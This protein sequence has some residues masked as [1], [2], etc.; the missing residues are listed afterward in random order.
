MA[1]A[2]ARGRY[3]GARSM[4]VGAGFLIAPKLGTWVWQREGPDTL[5][6]SCLMLGI[7]VALAL[8]VTGP[9]RR[10]RMAR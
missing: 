2:D 6:A 3:Q 10:R 8:A 7:V 4:M 9:A 5:W 1:P